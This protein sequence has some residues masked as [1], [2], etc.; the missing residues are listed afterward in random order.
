MSIEPTRRLGLVH[1]GLGRDL[2]QIDRAGH[3][4]EANVDVLSRVAGRSLVWAGILGAE[5]E[6]VVRLSPVARD[7]CADILQAWG[8]GVTAEIVRLGMGR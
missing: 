8:I 4:S 7:L 2:R 1:L 6:Q 5:A 3:R